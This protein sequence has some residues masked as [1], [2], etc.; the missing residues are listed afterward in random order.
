M[1]RHGW[2]FRQVVGWFITGSGLVILIEQ[3]LPLG[4]R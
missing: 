3:A 2:H 1:K 4:W